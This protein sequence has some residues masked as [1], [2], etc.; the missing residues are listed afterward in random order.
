FS[1]ESKYRNANQDPSNTKDKTSDDST[2]H[3]Q[4]KQES[5]DTS[6]KPGLSDNRELPV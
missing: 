4:S 3:N 2:S 1:Q 6:C 5:Q